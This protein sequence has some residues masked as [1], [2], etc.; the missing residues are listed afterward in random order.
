M[1]KVA[2]IYGTNREKACVKVVDWLKKG[3]EEEGHEVTVGK[4]SKFD[5]LDYDL[6]VLGSSVY[7]GK[8]QEDVIQ[9]VTMNKDVL[10]GKRLATFIVCKETK[11]PETHMEQILCL[12]TE[13]PVQQ[14]F[15]EGY[16]FREKNF[17]RQEQ[18]A[19][20][21]VKAVIGSVS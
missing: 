20:D 15:I 19:K 6:I 5:V 13:D 17:G 8:V 1:M 14:M 7:G 3:F 12:L 16:M 11:T 4:P 9:F 2:I 18:K 10:A 21:W